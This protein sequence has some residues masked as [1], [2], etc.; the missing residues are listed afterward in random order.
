MVVVDTTIVNVALPAISRDLHAGLG[1]LQWVVD[2]YVLVLASF[3]LS[4]GA[5]VDRIGSSR[6]FVGGV[7]LF[8]AS[9]I[10]CAV[11]PVIDVLLVA[12][13]MQGAA[14]A[15]LIPAS[16][17]LIA[18]AYPDA[19]ARA[20][21]IALFTT[22]AGS[23]QAFGPVIGGVLVTTL[24]WRS[25]FFVNVP[26]GAVTI[27]MALRGGVP[28]NSTQN[29]QLDWLG[30]ALAISTLASLTA[31][32]IEG[33]AQGWSKPLPLAA[34]VIAIV[35]GIAFV[36]RQRRAAVPLLPLDMVTPRI[37]GYVG[38][39]M[40]LFAAYYGVVFS[41]SL[42]LQNVRHLNAFLTGL[43][44]LPSA[45]PVFLL[46]VLIGPFVVKYGARRVVRVGALLGAFG[47]ISLFF[48][49]ITSIFSV[50]VALFL[51]GCGVGLTVSPQI[52]LLLGSVPE[53]YSGI[54]SG[55]LNAGRQTGYV[56]GVA[57][58]GSLGGLPSVGLAAAAILL[59][60]LAIC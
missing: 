34:L 13:F 39:G 58:L 59:L 36:H 48:L 16:M 25:I 15:L 4:G 23:P 5:L 44:F 30:Q 8:V 7:G 29:R 50:S 35:A 46:P 27:W 10:L 26:I 1:A 53:R 54:T 11:A 33:H 31:G 51:L 57:V 38:I 43:Q 60:T 9:S 45:L 40:L 47:G 19:T 42:Y 21:A 41:M 17:A 3:L 2:G 56:L 32:L 6:M 18:R 20:R 37:A 14:A 55:L 49:D 52:S 28:S 12:R 22:V 24:G